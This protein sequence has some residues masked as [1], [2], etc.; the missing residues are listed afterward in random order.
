MILGVY[1]YFGFPAGLYNYDYFRF[2]EGRGGIAGAPAELL[3]DVTVEN[4]SLLLHELQELVHAFEDAFIFAYRSGKYLRI[5]IGSYMLHDFEFE[6]ALKVE[7]I[8]KRN[9]ALSN[10]TI[11]LANAELIK[12]TNENAT[13]DSYPQNSFLQVVGS[14]LRKYNAE[15]AAVRSDCNVRTS[16]KRD[17]LQA[18]KNV[19]ESANFHVIFYM[20]KDLGE[21]C[22]LM[23]FFTN[24]RQGR[25]LIP[26][27]KIDL[28]RFEEGLD[29]II[30]EHDTSIGHIPGFDNYPSGKYKV[31]QIVDEEF[32]IQ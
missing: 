3:A 18:I 11:E 10:T 17:F 25:G 31:L 6:L 13:P 32:I 7:E 19:A 14:P 21:R 5:G 26:K 8:L 27:K 9:K 30:E 24:G 29:S 4:A 12:L 20:E 22:N 15:T 16:E 23:L 2:K 1:W 28:N